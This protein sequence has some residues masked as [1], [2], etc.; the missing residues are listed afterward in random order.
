MA[1]STL[2]EG[3]LWFG[4]FS[5]KYEN[6]R[7]SCP[8][9]CQANCLMDTSAFVSFLATVV[10]WAL[11]HPLI[12]QLGCT[13]FNLFYPQW[14][15]FL[16]SIVCTL[17]GLAV[18]NG[19]G[20]QADSPVSGQIRPHCSTQLVKHFNGEENNTNCDIL[21]VSCQNYFVKQLWC[22]LRTAFI[23]STWP[24]HDMDNI[25]FCGY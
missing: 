18:H 22:L 20:W 6:S 25:P 2:R 12:R 23:V 10:W 16:S 21:T 15:Q 5:S 8:N 3:C 1:S 24:V 19:H 13:N 4:H 7:L 11:Q 14:W 17:R 9:L